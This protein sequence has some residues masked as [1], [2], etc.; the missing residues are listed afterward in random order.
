MREIDVGRDYPRLAALAARCEMMP[1]FEAA[2]P[3][4]DEVMPA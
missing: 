4:P 2:R 1:A 3:S